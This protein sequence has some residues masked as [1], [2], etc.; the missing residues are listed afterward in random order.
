MYI[1][2]VLHHGGLIFAIQAMTQCCVPQRCDSLSSI[3]AA[4]DQHYNM[5]WNTAGYLYHRYTV[6]IIVLVLL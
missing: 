4:S 6:V 5:S 2:P 3:A 1:M